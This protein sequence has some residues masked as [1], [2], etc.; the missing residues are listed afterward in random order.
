MFKGWKTVGWNVF[1]ALAP[2]AVV[3]LDKLAA[4]DLTQYMSAPLAI[5]AG[6]VIGGIGMWLRVVTTGPVGSKDVA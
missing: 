4:L 2:L 6:F 3:G 5:L 1:I